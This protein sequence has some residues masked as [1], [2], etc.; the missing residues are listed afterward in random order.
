[1]LNFLLSIKTGVPGVAFVLPDS[2]IDPQIKEYGGVII[3][4]ESLKLVLF[5]FFWA[6]RGL[7]LA[8][9]KLCNFVN[10][11]II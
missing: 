3:I 2:Y 5:S 4:T 6:N 1:M 8:N 9:I 10:N 7:C 11:M